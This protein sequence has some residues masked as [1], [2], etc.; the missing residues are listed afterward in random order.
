MRLL[1]ITVMNCAEAA[2]RVR[3]IQNRPG[4]YQDAPIT[5]LLRHL[6][7][8]HHHDIPFGSMSF[9]EANRLHMQQYGGSDLTPGETP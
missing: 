8:D 7:S 4:R 5:A 1:R 9:P 6:R 3:D 2:R